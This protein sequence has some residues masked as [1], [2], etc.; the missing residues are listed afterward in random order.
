[1]SKRKTARKATNGLGW[2]TGLAVLGLMVLAALVWQGLYRPLD[3]P[4]KGAL[5]RIES[6]ETYNGLLAELQ[7]RHGLRLPVLARLYRKLFIHDGLKAGVYRLEPG[8]D[9]RELLQRL[10]SGQMAEM[11]RVTLIE[12]H[13]FA[14]FQAQ[15]AKNTAIVHDLSGQR[16][17]QVAATLGM[18]GGRPEGWLAPDTYYFAPGS[19][20]TEILRTLHQKRARELEQLWANRA[21]GLPLN[22]PYEALILASIVE[23]ETGIPSERAEVAA[24]F[25]NRLRLGMRLQTDPTVIY[26]LMDAGRYDGNIRRADLDEKNAYN[27]YQI[28]GL[29]PTP[30]AMPSRAALQATLH[31]AS[32]PALYFVA[33]GKGGHAFASTLSEH[34]ANVARYLAQLRASRVAEKTS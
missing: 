2:V 10:A 18:G 32:T 21:P 16:P 25:I 3:I 7:Q 12:G 28:N 19:R 20:E 33:T 26:G 29:P 13:T 9:V 17:A 5:L 6:G 24:V 15:L 4:A 31:P 34:N 23:K 8:L 1:M 27:T 14:Q 30:I 22:T 11:L